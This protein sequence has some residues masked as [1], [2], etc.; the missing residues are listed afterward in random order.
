[1]QPPPTTFTSAPP[2]KVN[3][4]DKA[5]LPSIVKQTREI[6]FKK[7]IVS[8]TRSL[9]PTRNVPASENSKG[10]FNNQHRR[11]IKQASHSSKPQSHAAAV[12]PRKPKQPIVPVFNRPTYQKQLSDNL[13]FMSH[14][15]INEDFISSTNNELL[16]P[17]QAMDVFRCMLGS[18]RKC[19]TREDQLQALMEIVFKYL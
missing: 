7:P 6:Q 19:R 12:S 9:S 13:N 3:Y 4:W 8:R 15:N 10:P 18:L 1:M 11:P 14:S 5:K 2:P 16:S 17:S